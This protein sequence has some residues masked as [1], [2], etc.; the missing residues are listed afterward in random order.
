MS[1]LTELKKEANYTTTLNG[2]KTHSS[3]GDACLDLF[4]VAGGMRYRKPSDLK[5]MF[6][7]A[8]IENPELAMKLLFYIRDIRGGMGERKI[9]RILLRHVAF[10]W[11]ESAKKNIHLIAKYGRFD[12]LL[13]LLKT[14]VQK[15]AVD[16]ISQQLQEDWKAVERRENGEHDAPVSLLAKWLPSANA[17]SRK[18][19][20]NARILS[21]ALGMD[22]KSYRKMLSRLRAHC[23][24]TERYLARG[25]VEKIKYETVPSS[26]MLKYRDAFARRDKE[27][28]H[29]YLDEVANGTKKMNS[30]ILFPYEILRPYFK[31]SYYGIS[32]GCKVK[33]MD[34]LEALWN[35]QHIEVAETNAISVIDTSGSMYWS[36]G[37]GPLPALISQALGL[38][39]AE[40]C[41]GPFKNHVITFESNPHLI[42]LQGK[43][44]RDKLMYLQSLPWGGSTNLEAV[45]DLIL[46]TAVNA[47]ATQEEMPSVLYI[48]SDMEFNCAFRNPDKTIY[49]NAR[50]MFEVFGYQ[51][52][53]VVFH[54]VNSWQTQ[55]PVTAH[56]KGAALMSGAGV[57]S[58]KEKFDG[59]M[60]PMS[61][62]LKVLNSKR[63]EEVHA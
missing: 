37:D 63:Y 60:T 28:F 55:A 25:Q 20:D 45:F 38:R 8:Y 36:L 32:Y 44:L 11:P 34:V 10:Q 19:Q 21:N 18:T 6:T 50:E 13:C 61:H 46:R 16:L 2:A 12:D 33:G 9:F 41:K 43:T 29:T 31:D 59:N 51:L 56:T 3:T 4:A 1:F 27:R 54:N 48:I 26:A 17:S 15:Q 62:M 35:N 30:D 39:F 57:A 14:P 23:C 5:N 24:L 47:G 53:A 52:P 49:E 58:F 22:E 40:C 42:E 7:R